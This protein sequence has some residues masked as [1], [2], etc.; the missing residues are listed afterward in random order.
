MNI[1]GVFLSN[2][3][4]VKIL[5]ITQRAESFQTEARDVIIKFRAIGIEFCVAGNDLTPTLQLHCS[6]N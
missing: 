4:E 3:F 5:P 1:T 6:P 2:G